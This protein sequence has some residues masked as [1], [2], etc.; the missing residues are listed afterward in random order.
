MPPA[1]LSD[2]KGSVGL[3]TFTD[4]FLTENLFRDPDEDLG[5][6]ELSVVVLTAGMRGG[7]RTRRG[8][9]RLRRDVARATITPVVVC[10]AISVMICVM[11]GNMQ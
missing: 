5:V 6:V 8:E 10:D 7:R 4:S 2:V 1:S 9:L 11:T 3:I